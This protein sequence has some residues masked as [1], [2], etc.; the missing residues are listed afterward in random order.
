M[1]V[2][3]LLLL[4]NSDQVKRD[5]LSENDEISKGLQSDSSRNMMLEIIG[6]GLLALFVFIIG[7]THCISQR[8]MKS[9]VKDISQ[10][11]S[12]LSKTQVLKLNLNLEATKICLESARADVGKIAV[13][14][15]MLL[16]VFPLYSFPYFE[17]LICNCLSGGTP[18]APNS[19]R[20]TLTFNF[21]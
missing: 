13:D 14:I 15:V 4:Q 11:M 6:F 2:N 7:V 20:F 18:L 17:V 3:F 10:N 8:T 19:I 5:I 1:C 21:I 9:H 16:Q 12:K